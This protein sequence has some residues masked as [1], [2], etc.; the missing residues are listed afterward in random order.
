MAVKF[1]PK[2]TMQKNVNISLTIRTF[3]LLG[4]C[5]IDFQSLVQNGLAKNSLESVQYRLTKLC[6]TVLNQFWV[7]VLWVMQWKYVQLLKMTW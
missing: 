5:E 3:A 6:G 1:S 2:Y 4:V 7:K